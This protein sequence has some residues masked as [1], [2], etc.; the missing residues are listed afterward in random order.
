MRGSTILAVIFVATATPALAT[1]QGSGPQR[2]CIDRYGHAYSVRTFGN[3][4]YMTGTTRYGAS[5]HE[6]IVRL[7]KST[8]TSAVSAG[9]PWQ[10]TI[11]RLGDVTALAGTNA[12]GSG[13]SILCT[14]GYDDCPAP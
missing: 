1:C 12:D 7:G 13:F 2:R 8:Y 14:A 6:Q 3:T 4:T 11:T 10:R 5:W 9:H